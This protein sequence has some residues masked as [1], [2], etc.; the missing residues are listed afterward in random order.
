M[1][2]QR[3][4]RL[5]EGWEEVRVWVPSAAHADEIRALASDMRRQARALEPLKEQTPMI[6][7]ETLEKI[8]GALAQY[9]SVK[10]NTPSGSLTDEL[11]VLAKTGDLAAFSHAFAA[12]ATAKPQAAAYIE[13]QVPAII[14]NSYWYGFKAVSFQ[15]WRDLDQKYPDWADALK[16][17]V[18]NVGRFEATIADIEARMVAH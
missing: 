9:G 2:R 5:N 7:A 6:T 3:A 15:K 12:F 18:R 14:L 1:Q 17:S 4:L 11:G 16:K 8:A 13:G 10:F